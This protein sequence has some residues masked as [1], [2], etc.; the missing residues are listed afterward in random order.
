MLAYFNRILDNLAL[1]VEHANQ[2]RQRAAGVV[3]LVVGEPRDQIVHV[4]SHLLAQE[5]TA[6]GVLLQ[7]AE[8]QVARR[9]IASAK[10]LAQGVVGRSVVAFELR[11]KSFDRHAHHP[12]AA[13]LGHVAL[14]MGGIEPLLGD[15][16]IELFDQGGRDVFH[17]PPSQAVFDHQ[18]L[19]SLDGSRRHALIFG[20]EI[21]GVLDIDAEHVG[22]GGFLGGPIHELH[23][24]DQPTH[25]VEFLSGLADGRI[26]VFLHGVDRHQLQDG[27]A[28]QMLPS[29][30]ATLCR[31]TARGC[32]GRRQTVDFVV[33]RLRI[34][35]LTELL[36]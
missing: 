19:V 26:E 35:Y 11:E 7:V 28:K 30:G 15:A 13:E 10:R 2:H 5:L 23:E 32:P 16:Q 9:L 17:D 12:R 3:L 22:A 20:T 27:L 21:Q 33:G 14:D 25:G 4:V 24:E 18:L 8:K 1:F 6:F 31:P 34:A 36:S 29:G